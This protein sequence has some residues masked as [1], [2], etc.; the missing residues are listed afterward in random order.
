MKTIVLVG[1]SFLALTVGSLS[2]AGDFWGFPH[3]KKSGK[4]EAIAGCMFS[5]KTD[6][7]IRR[8]D[9]AQHAHKKVQAF[10]H[11]FDTRVKES[12]LHAHNGSSFGAI[13]IMS[14]ADLI[15]HLDAQG[16]DVD[17]IVIDE[18]QFFGE[19]MVR[20]VDKLVADG[21][22]VI[23]AGLDMDFLGRPFGITPTLLAKAD[24]VTKKEARCFICGR[25]A[26]F[27]QRLVN[28]KPAKP[29]DPLIL[30]GAEECYQARCRDC[31]EIGQEEGILVQPAQSTTF[32][33]DDPEAFNVPSQ[34]QNTNTHPEE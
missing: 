9:A 20:C 14:G 26:H 11:A 3:K 22:R 15:A 18:V 33:E 8:I 23:V 32:V 27:T 4:I 21:K 10:K 5:G 19:E 16:D 2:M 1:I 28:G 30:I 24:K 25:K 6:E 34:Q 7:L 29:S 17:V 13:C 31:F 12:M